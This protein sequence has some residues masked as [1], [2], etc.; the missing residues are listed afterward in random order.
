MFFW[1]D[2]THHDRFNDLTFPGAIYKKDIARW[3]L[4]QQ[5]KETDQALNDINLHGAY[6]PSL[7]T[8][9]Q[10][11]ELD[12]R[13]LG[14]HY[15]APMV[16]AGYHQYRYEPTH[17]LPYDNDGVDHSASQMVE[18]THHDYTNISSY[19]N[20]NHYDCDRRYEDP[21]VI[22]TSTDYYNHQQVSTEYHAP[23]MSPRRLPSIHFPQT[24]SRDPN[25]DKYYDVPLNHRI[26]HGEYQETKWENNSSSKIEEYQRH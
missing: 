1:L 16:P 12:P 26:S 10:P 25:H 24:G 11:P 8:L 4:I 14:S 3:R 21:R 15:G 5:Q 22:E 6:D 20:S 13:D 23:H 18:P 19:D 9:S 17:K 7:H 2:S